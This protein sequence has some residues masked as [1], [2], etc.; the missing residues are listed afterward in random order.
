MSNYDK[1]HCEKGKITTKDHSSI[2]STEVP[3]IFVSNSRRAFRTPRAM[4]ELLYR[5]CAKQRRESKQTDVKFQ[6]TKLYHIV[7]HLEIQLLR[8][9]CPRW[10]IISMGVAKI[11][12]WHL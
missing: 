9:V 4:C 8:K 7:E 1:K 11:C 5:F 12:Y 3:A 2:V 6:I 10:P